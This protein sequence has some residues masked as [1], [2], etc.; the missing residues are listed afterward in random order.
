[1]AWLLY[2]GA[3]PQ[4]FVLHA[5]D[6]RR[7]VRREHL[8]LGDNAAN[9]ADMKAKGRADRTKKLRGEGQWN[10]RA[11]ES[12]VRE[13][14]LRARA[15]EKQRILAGEYGLHEASVSDIVLR[16]TWRHVV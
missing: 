9:M 8:F 14:R 13:I 4:A 10:S 15:G 12:V 11:T 6:N 5:C 16:K 2:H 3:P 7:C 1:V